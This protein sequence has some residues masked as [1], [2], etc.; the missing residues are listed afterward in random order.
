M[1]PKFRVMFD[2]GDS[3]EV[4]SR[5]RDY[6]KLEREG[7]NIAELPPIRGSYQLAHLVLSRLARTGDISPSEPLPESVDGLIDVADLEV[8][9]DDDPEGKD[10]GQGPRTG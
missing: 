10:S 4:A 5:T 9:E 3:F 8:V 6:E 1:N 7:V 2:N